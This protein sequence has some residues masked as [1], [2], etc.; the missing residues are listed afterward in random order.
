MVQWAERKIMHHESRMYQP[1]EG[2]L[3]SFHRSLPSQ[4]FGLGLGLDPLEM[5]NRGLHG[6]KQNNCHILSH[7]LYQLFSGFKQYFPAFF[8]VK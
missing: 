4:S 5:L 2:S 3:L 8:N 6:K 1:T 7:H